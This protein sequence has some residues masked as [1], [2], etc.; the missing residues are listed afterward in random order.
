MP[1]YLWMSYIWTRYKWDWEGQTLRRE[2]YS[3]VGGYSL[4]ISMYHPVSHEEEEV[5]DMEAKWKRVMG[6]VVCLHITVFL[7]LVPHLYSYGSLWHC[8]NTACFSELY[9]PGPLGWPYLCSVQV[10]VWNSN[11]LSSL[12]NGEEHLNKFNRASEI[13]CLS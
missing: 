10:W 1:L 9:S 12:Q 6:T 11:V 3:N 7:G 8:V 4:G 13:L 2:K 5:R